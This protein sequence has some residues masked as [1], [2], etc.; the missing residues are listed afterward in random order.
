MEISRPPWRLVCPCAIFLAAPRAARVRSPRRQAKELHFRFVGASGGGS[1]VEHIVIPW[2]KEETTEAV[3]CL[4]YRYDIVVDR[5]EDERVGET[6]RA[7]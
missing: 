5:V 7:R 1:G 4:T 2:M 3:V 6:L